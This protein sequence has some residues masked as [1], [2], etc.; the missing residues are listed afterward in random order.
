MGLL[1]LVDFDKIYKSF[2]KTPLK[3][4]NIRLYSEIYFNASN[5]IFLLDSP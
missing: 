1:R 5:N 2:S 4:K 3:F